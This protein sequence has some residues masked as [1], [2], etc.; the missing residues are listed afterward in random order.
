[1]ITLL[2]T[3][4]TIYSVWLYDYFTAHVSDNLL[5]MIVW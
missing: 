2:Y 1:M 3:S 4:V 5:C